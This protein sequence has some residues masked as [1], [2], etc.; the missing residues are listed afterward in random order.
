M[1][2][3]LLQALHG[4]G[5]SIHTRAIVRFYLNQGDRVW[6][7][8]CW[9]S[10]YTD[11]AAVYPGKLKFIKTD[12]ALRTQ[13]KNAAQCAAFWTKD[14]LPRN[15]ITI[16]VGYKPEKV[17]ECGSV[18]HAILATAGVPVAHDDF[19]FDGLVDSSRDEGMFYRPL[20]NR[21][22]WGGCSA[23]NPDQWS[24]GALAYSLSNRFKITSIA[25]LEEGKEWIE[26]AD[27][28][29]SRKWHTGAVGFDELCGYIR[30]AELAFAS[31]GF[32]V[33]LAQALGT[34]VVVCY[35]G[36]EKSSSFSAGAK[37]TATLGID[38]IRPCD[39]FMHNHD[40]ARDKEI[41]FENA[42]VSLNQFVS[43]NC[44]QPMKTMYTMSDED[45]DRTLVASKEF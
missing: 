29:A 16:R 15:T 21:I 43:F 7:T 24:Y 5:D 14:P 13:K 4:L 11:L 18:L 10:V 40:C 34:P 22:E 19:R 26:G 38:K 42:M 1:S 41:D 33:P 23:R 12:S 8:T 25:D 45:R 30:H 31:P 17:R 9:P 44:L 37:Y 32:L 2:E 35:G 20:V 3:I 36:Y 6:I 27:I 39:C 28:P